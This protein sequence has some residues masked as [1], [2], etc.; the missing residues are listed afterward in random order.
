MKNIFIIA[1][2]L[3]LSACSNLGKPANVSASSLNVQLGLAYLQ[4][5]ERSLAKSKLMLAIEQD[6]KNSAAYSAMGYFLEKSGASDN[7]EKYYLQAIQVAS[8]N[9]KGAS[10]NNYGTYLY[11]EHR[12]KDALYYF[13]QAIRDP[14]YLHVAE[15]YENAGLA[16]LGE[17]NYNA[18]RVFF[19]RALVS[20]PKCKISRK[21]LVEINNAAKI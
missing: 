5:N 3:L 6:P 8:P 17:Y 19:N 2:C 10:L 4:N 12:Y 16:A 21:K 20:D 11:R 9:N 18:A 1:S 7:A 14:K 13:M 15:A